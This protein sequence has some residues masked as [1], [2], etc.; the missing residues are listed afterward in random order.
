MYNSNYIKAIE[1]HNKKVE[2]KKEG[3]E[4]EELGETARGSTNSARE[5]GTR[6]GRTQH[7]EKVG[8]YGNELIKSKRL[9]Q[10]LRSD[11]ERVLV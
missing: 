2:T 6:S 11:T 9:V 8:S 1:R 3:I 7:N 5:R 4:N 10:E